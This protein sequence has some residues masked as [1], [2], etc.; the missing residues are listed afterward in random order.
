MCVY[1]F[2]YLFIDL[3]INLFIYLYLYPVAIWLL[4]ICPS[5]IFAIAPQ[6][7]RLSYMRCENAISCS[8][9]CYIV[10]QTVL[11]LPV[12]VLGANGHA[13]IFQ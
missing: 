10:Q 5:F 13:C 7:C 2:I 8:Q 4:C 11:Y 1:I 9:E 12:C 3:L 6:M